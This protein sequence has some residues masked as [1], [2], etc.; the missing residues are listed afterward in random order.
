MRLVENGEQQKLL[1]SRHS[2]DSDSAC[3]A[4][5][6]ELDDFGAGALHDTVPLS[7]PSTS[8][9]F[10]HVFWR[11]RL[12]KSF[13][14]RLRARPLSHRLMQCLLVLF[15]LTLSL[16]V[17]CSAF[18]PSYSH[19]PD[20]YTLLR[21]RTQQTPQTPGRANTQNAKVFVAAS[22]Y[23]PEGTLVSGDWG[24]SVLGLI[25]ILGPEN[26]FL[27]IYEDNA[28]EKS[29][30]ALDD[31][32]AQLSCNASL[33]AEDLDVSQLP[34]VSTPDGTHKLS[35]IAFL[36]EV[37]NR[38]LR[39]LCNKDLSAFSTR[40]DRLLY[41]NDVLF[42]PVDAAN[43]LFS[44]NVD[45]QTGQTL[46]LAACAVDFI[47]TIKFYDTFATRDVEGYD[48]GVPFYPW[49]TAAGE[50]VSR[51]DVLAQKDAVRVKSCWGGMVAFEARWFQPWMY[52]AGDSGG[53]GNN[54][55]RPPL[56][57]RAENE[58][59]WESSECCLVHA[60]LTALASEEL[61]LG[62]TGIF[63]NPYVRVA[64]SKRVLKWLHLT[65]RVER[66]Y[67]PLHRLVNAIAKRPGFNERRM[68][69]PG[70]SV[71][72]RTWVWNADS[73][74]ELPHKMLGAYR[75]VR[76][77]ASPGGFCG[78]RHLSFINEHPGQ[79]EERWGTVRAPPD[80]GEG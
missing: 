14:F 29:K 74:E 37:R 77:I 51:R 16:V 49:F 63:M 60:D 21:Q 13:S 33:V 6:L 50:A 64:Y 24:Q 15:I 7:R 48:M 39:P 18:F 70:E 3:P 35:R 58:S 66:L 28:D 72:D 31:F 38:A 36:A 25:D 26:V 45:E 44:T 80:R 40:F 8:F 71:V 73:G 65:K 75:S 41:L 42:D 52:D 1:S 46:Y 30:L 34:H 59:F 47:D 23:D 11:D 4:V 2:E 17:V 12:R 57:F 5:D 10:D 68:Q 67:S 79:G 20:R 22:L 27:S 53:L 9:I 78:V 43:L 69:Q 76:R 61:D 56:R 62:G 54:T 32:A 55:N 19:P